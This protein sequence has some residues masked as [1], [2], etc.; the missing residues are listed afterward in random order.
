MKPSIFNTSL[1][2]DLHTHS[3][4]H[5]DR[6]DI[7]EVISSPHP[8]NGNSYSLER[9]PW[10]VDRVADEAEQIKIKSILQDPNCLALGEV[11]L[12]KLK[13]VSFEEQQE[14]LRS[15][16]V[17]AAHEKR[18]VILHCVKAFDEIIQFKK[19]FES[20]PNW[21][22][23]GFNK[24]PQLAEQLIGHGFYLSINPQKSTHAKELLDTIPM[25]R[26]FLETDNSSFFIEDNYLRASEMLGVQLEE[27]KKNITQ[28]AKHFFGHE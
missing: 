13:G 27:L 8:L 10:N 17:V 9:H 7:L 16:L 19:E 1:F 14:I 15:I 6:A 24:H 20:I 21:A 28:N 5:S 25:D 18:P 26:L 2:I 12:D 11:G 3:A 23:H 4:T 22:I